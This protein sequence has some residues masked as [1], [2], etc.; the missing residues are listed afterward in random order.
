MKI[1]N[2]IEKSYIL[3]FWGFL[4]LS[5]VDNSFATA[6]NISKLYCDLG[7]PVGIAFNSTGD[8]FVAEWSA[9]KVT[10]FDTSGNRSTFADSL[11]GPSGLAIDSSDNVYVASYSDDLIYK[12]SASGQRILFA[13]DMGTPAGLSFDGQGNLLVANRQTNEIISIAPDGQ[14]QIIATGLQTPVGAVITSEGSYFVSNINGGISLVTQEH[15]VK[16]INSQLVRPGPGIAINNSDQVFVVDYGSTMVYQVNLKGTL[17][18]VAEGLPSPAG[19]TLDK[20]GNLYAAT[21]GDGAI[22]KITLNE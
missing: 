22:Y 1:N 20:N 13:K 5:L 3:A 21:W 19:L 7:G 15:R 6:A 16:T 8:L 9:G 12:Y 10:R 4:A 18:L 2:R 17:S 14:R 11:N